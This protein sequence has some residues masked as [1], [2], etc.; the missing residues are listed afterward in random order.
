MITA[1]SVS[2]LEPFAGGT[3]A[4]VVRLAN[5]LVKK[6]HRI[7]VLCHSASED[8]LFNTIKLEESPYRLCDAVT[9]EEDAQQLYQ[10][11]Q[12]GL[13]DLSRYDV[14]HFHS[15]FTAMY[16][17]SVFQERQNIITLH[18]PPSPRLT[19]L[20]QLHSA[21]SDDIYVS[22]SSRLATEWQ[23][24][25]NNEIHVIHNGITLPDDDVLTQRKNQLLWVGRICEDKD[26]TTAIEC[27]RAIDMRLII[28]GPIIN[29]DY[30]DHRVAPQLSDTIQYAGHLEQGELSSLYLTSKAL[31]NT[32]KWNEPFGLTTLEALSYGTPVIGFTT[33]L[34]PELRIPPYTQTLPSPDIAH[35]RNAIETVDTLDPLS[36]RKVASLF[37]LDATVTEYEKRY[38]DVIG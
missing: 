34:P 32:A 16:D 31:L 36:C 1:P 9:S 24:L 17:F 23:P 29:Q 37:S 3:E 11:A 12:L 20:H 10:A 30:F 27:A 5:A 22:V 4:F 26:V 18:T 14:V 13:A 8:N 19:A 15:Y 28:A 6:G 2:L 33:S 25:I 35:L 7:D 21:R 38:L